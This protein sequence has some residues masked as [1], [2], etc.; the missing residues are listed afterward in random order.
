MHQSFIP[1]LRKIIQ[2]QT[3][4]LRLVNHQYQGKQKDP[5]NKSFPGL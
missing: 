2:Q 5:G 4:Q 3:K 1:R